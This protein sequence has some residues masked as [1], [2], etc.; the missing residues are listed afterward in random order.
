MVKA[1][2]IIAEL[3]SDPDKKRPKSGTCFVLGVLGFFLLIVL[4]IL[5]VMVLPRLDQLKKGRTPG[6]SSPQGRSK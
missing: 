2:S 5:C 6:G 4:V 3:M 1:I